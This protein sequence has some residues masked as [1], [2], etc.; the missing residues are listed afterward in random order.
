MADRLHTTGAILEI[1]VDDVAGMEAAIVGGADRLELCAALACGGLTPS[2][3]LM[4]QA[5]AAQIPVHAMIRPRSGSFVFSQAEVQVM[6]RDIA[7]VRHMGLA[8]VVLGALLPDGRLDCAA[9]RQLLAASEG[10]DVTL[11]RAFDLVPDQLE[12]LA[13]AVDLGFR[14]ILTSGGQKSAPVGIE[15]LKQLFAAAKGR[16]SIMPGGG[17]NAEN[18]NLFADV[19][20]TEFHASCSQPQSTA[21]NLV[22]FGFELAASRRTDEQ[23]VREMKQR[24]GALGSRWLN[25][26]ER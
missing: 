20:M 25:S 17:V 1:C 7:A 23:T 6:I 3:G 24:M 9:L 13:E 15:A 5:A 10:L 21:R 14:R 8:G 22:D 18:L 16:I 2:I 12:A 26:F 19:G 11:H 4:A